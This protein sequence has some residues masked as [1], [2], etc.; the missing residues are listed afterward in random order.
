MGPAGFLMWG[1]HCGLA[2]GFWV[3]AWRFLGV[4]YQGAGGVAAFMYGCM[5]GQVRDTVL[6]KSCLGPKTGLR[7]CRP[8]S[9]TA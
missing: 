4:G 5:K 7:A 6:Y 8:F 9:N 2:F 1:F 3:E